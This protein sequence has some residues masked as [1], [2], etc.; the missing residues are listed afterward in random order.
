MQAVPDLKYITTN[1]V[2]VPPPHGHLLCPPALGS[3]D[4]E[5]AELE[6]GIYGH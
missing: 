1:L 4:A 6:D 5:V 3:Y 2:N